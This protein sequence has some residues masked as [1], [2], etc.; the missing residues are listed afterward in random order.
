MR[1][2]L[3]CYKTLCQ[4]KCFRKHVVTFVEDE[5][6]ERSVSKQSETSWDIENC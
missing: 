6:E 5:T 2:F 3:Q 1:I 4:G